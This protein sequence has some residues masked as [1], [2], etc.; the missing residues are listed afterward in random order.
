MREER[1]IYLGEKKGARSLKA[2]RVKGWG[3]RGG[4]WNE[5]RI[6]RPRR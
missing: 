3:T 5:R 2:V 6:Y 4:W 1:V